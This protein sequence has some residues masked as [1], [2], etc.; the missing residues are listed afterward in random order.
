MIIQKL[1]IRKVDKIFKE[2]RPIS[3]PWAKSTKPKSLR[4]GAPKLNI[5]IIYKPILL[6]Q[7]VKYN[8]HLY[9]YKPSRVYRPTSSRI[10][11]ISTQCLHLTTWVLQSIQE[12]FI[13]CF[14]YSHT[15]HAIQEYTKNLTCFFIE[16]STNK[17]SHHHA[18]ISLEE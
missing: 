16:L 6:R 7:R 8:L 13:V 18:P 15:F 3:N 9:F 4:D 11:L 14:K 2:T 12:L 5:L 17:K 10:Y 1:L